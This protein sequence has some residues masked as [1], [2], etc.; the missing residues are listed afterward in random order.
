MI[1]AERKSTSTV[2]HMDHF[3]EIMP[4]GRLTAPSD[5]KVYRL[6]EA[7]AHSKKIGRPLTEDKMKQ[8]EV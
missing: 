6:K 1:I 2:Y 7:I 8:Y 3:G 4:D 5:Q